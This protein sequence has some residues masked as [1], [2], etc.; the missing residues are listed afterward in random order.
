MQV[1]QVL[2]VLYVLFEWWV[3]LLQDHPFETVG[4]TL[5]SMFLLMAIGDWLSKKF[6]PLDNSKKR[7]RQTY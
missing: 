2:K 5:F 6:S 4:V 1:R 7:Y 3:V